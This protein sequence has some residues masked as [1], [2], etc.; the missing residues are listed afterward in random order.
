MFDY[1]IKNILRR[2]QR[3][4]L[5]IAGLSVMIMLVIVITG[6]VNYQIR[7]M[8]EHASAVT[9]KV[10][11]QSMLAGTDYPAQGVDLDE[12]MADRILDR[13]N[14]QEQLSAKVVYYEIEPPLYPTN[15]PQVLLVGVE[16]GKEDAFTGSVAYAVPP[17]EGVKSFAGV[18]TAYPVILGE[19]TRAYYESTL[20]ESLHEGDTLSIMDR[21]FIIVGILD[22]ANDQVVN[23]ALIVPLSSAQALLGKQGYVSS[24][25]LTSTMVKGK[26][27]LIAGIEAQFPEINIVT[28]DIIQKNAQDG[29]QLFETM[30][31]MISIVVIAGIIILMMVVMSLAIKERTKEIGVLRAIGTS[32]HTIILS[33]FIEIFIVSVAGSILGG[34]VSG[35]ILRFAMMENIFDFAHILRCMPLSVVITAIAGILPAVKISRILPVTALAYE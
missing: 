34:V 11:V 18:D 14:I 31:K 5:T 3:S 24:V 21:D 33:I 30:I 23:N 26:T 27:N 2:W 8:N 12:S 29:I 6:I 10:H 4:T 19:K 15:P 1:A 25:I 13:E 28:D 9:G 22:T 7:I 17:V 35:I 16:P 32:T 20:G